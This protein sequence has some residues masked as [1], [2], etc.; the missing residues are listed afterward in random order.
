MHVRFR[1]IKQSDRK[2]DDRFKQLNDEPE[3]QF[4]EDRFNQLKK[5][6]S[7]TSCQV[8]EKCQSQH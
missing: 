7:M 1:A 5:N 2:I 3:Q 6:P 4:A 8:K